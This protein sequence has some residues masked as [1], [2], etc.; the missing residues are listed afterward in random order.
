M[1]LGLPVSISGEAPGLIN[2]EG[3]TL[4]YV[5][6]YIHWNLDLSQLKKLCLNSI[7]YSCLGQ[8]DVLKKKFDEDWIEFIMKINN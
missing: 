4:D 5:L 7:E 8:K 6:C 1:N 3:V 2:Y